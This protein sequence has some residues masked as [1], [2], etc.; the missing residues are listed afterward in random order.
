MIPGASGDGRGSYSM[1]LPVLK[2][3]TL[4]E[5]HWKMVYCL[6]SCTGE[7]PAL[8]EPWNNCPFIAFSGCH[9]I[10]QLPTQ[11]FL[12]SICQYKVLD[13]FFLPMPYC[14]SLQPLRHPRLTSFDSPS[15]LLWVTFKVEL[16]EGLPHSL[17]CKGGTFV[18]RSIH[19]N[20]THL[21]NLVLKIN[22]IW[23]CYLKYLKN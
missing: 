12:D 19:L 15:W 21:L 8:Q 14:C 11:V 20:D 13:Y 17:H 16:T 9:F 2:I 4:I 1:D 7:L 22:V 10:F 5:V 6:K 3:G 18:K 23:Y